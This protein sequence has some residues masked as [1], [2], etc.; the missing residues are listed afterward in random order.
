[1]ICVNKL[2]KTNKPKLLL[3]LCEDISKA[4]FYCGKVFYKICGET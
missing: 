4:K 3:E 1:M 2:R